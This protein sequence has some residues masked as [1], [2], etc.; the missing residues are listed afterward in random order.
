MDYKIF[1][2]VYRGFYNYWQAIYNV[3]QI[4]QK[5]DELI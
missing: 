1:K 2:L 5:Y 3:F 4:F